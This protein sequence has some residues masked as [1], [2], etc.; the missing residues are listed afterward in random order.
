MM[1]RC[2][3]IDTERKNFLARR[4]DKYMSD[5]RGG[6]AL[7]ALRDALLRLGGEEVCLQFEEDLAKQA[8][9]LGPH[10]S[11]GVVRGKN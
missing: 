3:R 6:K 2:D 11:W 1:P 4:N 5:P 7:G 10:S 9:S 8:G